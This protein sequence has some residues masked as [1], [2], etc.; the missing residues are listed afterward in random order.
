MSMRIHTALIAIAFALTASTVAHAGGGGASGA[1][2]STAKGNAAQAQAD[3][4]F[5]AGGAHYRAGEYQEAITAFTDAYALVHDPV[6]LFNV[7]QSYRKLLDCVNASSYYQRYLAEAADAS[8]RAKVEQWLREL[9]TCVDQRHAEVEAARKQADTQA[10]PTTTPPP[11]SG[12]ASTTVTGTAPTKLAVTSD[13]DPGHGKRV[14]GIVVGGVG[15]VALAIGVGYAHHGASIENEIKADC[16]SS[17]GCNWD[18]GS[19]AENSKDSA[20]KSANTIAE[21]S[22]IGGGV[23]VIAG[24]A[25]YYLGMRGGEHITVAPT[26]NGGATAGMSWSF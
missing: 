14:A 25:L 9:Q 3:K 16:A 19:G 4:L 12:T 11:S 2:S 17:A 21:I 22:L 15:I 13:A 18:T 20:G 6:Y 7:A 8:N 1:A 5:A 10:T 26:A 24:A 23:A